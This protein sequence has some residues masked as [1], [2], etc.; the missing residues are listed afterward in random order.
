MKSSKNSTKRKI[1]Q[2]QN[3]L[4]NRRLVFMA[5]IDGAGGAALIPRTAV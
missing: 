5:I 1:T 3:S 2:T 4:L